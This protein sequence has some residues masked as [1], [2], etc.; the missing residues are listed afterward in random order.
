MPYKNPTLN[1]RYYLN[2]TEMTCTNLHNGSSTFR[3]DTNSSH[4]CPRG[5]NTWQGYRKKKSRCLIYNNGVQPCL[6]KATPLT[7][8]PFGSRTWKNNISWYT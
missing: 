3:C 8:G 6:V 4:Y 5:K 1:L 2:V 7:M